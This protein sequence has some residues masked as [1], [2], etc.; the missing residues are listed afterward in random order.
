MKKTAIKFIVLSVIF[1][2]GLYGDLATKKLATR[3]LIGGH[4]VT[5]IKDVLEFTYTENRGMIFGLLNDRPSPLKH[6]GLTVLTIPVSYT[7][8]TLPTN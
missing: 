8:L 2:G 4:T 3:N 1:L 5:V 7:H 6:Y